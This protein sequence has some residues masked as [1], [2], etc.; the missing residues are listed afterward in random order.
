MLR[1][2]LTKRRKG[3]T[4]LE[5]MVALTVFMI[6]VGI[7]MRSFVHLVGLQIEANRYRKVYSELN[8]VITLISTDAREFGIDY[9]CLQ[10]A[11][12][13]PKSKLGF[14]SRDG[15]QRRVIKV[16]KE[17]PTEPTSPFLL[18]YAIQDRTSRTA[19][20]PAE[21]F[22]SLATRNTVFTNFSLEL[23]PLTNPYDN[24]TEV[25]A[26]NLLQ[27]SLSIFAEAKVKSALDRPGVVMQTSVSSRL[28]NVRTF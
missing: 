26:A 14:V 9:E 23:R 18:S 4:L 28:Y 11:E 2:L 21:S 8:E 27:P 10:T 19:D 3:F 1:K 17:D 6:F 16:E 25:T 20:W 7:I 24:A 12:C 5:I 13:D 15:L 22:Q